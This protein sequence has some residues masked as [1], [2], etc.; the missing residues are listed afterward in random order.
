MNSRHPGQKAMVNPLII[1]PAEENGPTRF[2]VI[3][4]FPLVVMGEITAFIVAARRSR[5][6]FSTDDFNRLDNVSAILSTCMEN[7]SGIKRARLHADNLEAHN[8]ILVETLPDGLVR[9]NN[10]FEVLEANR[11]ASE[12][13]QLKPEEIIGMKCFDT[14]CN[15]K[16]ST[17]PVF[18]SERDH[19][20]FESTLP[21]H[22]GQGCN[23]VHVLKSTRRYSL[24]GEKFAICTF[25]DIS[26]LKLMDQKLKDYAENLEKKVEERTA[27]LKEAQRH[28]L[29]SEKLAATGRL[30]A[31]I[32]HEINSPVYGIK[33]CLQ[34]IRDELSLDADLRGFVDLSLEET[35]RISD[36]IRKM[37]N[38]NRVSDGKRSVQDIKSVLKDML[39]LCNPYLQEKRISLQTSFDRK[40][41]RALVC[42]D[43]I[44]QVFINL[45]NNAVEAM[46]DG[47]KLIISTRM[48]GATMEIAFEDSGCGMSTE[49]K[50]R[51][52]DAF[53]TTKSAVKGV[54]LGLPMCWGIVRRHGGNIL[55]DS[56]PGKGSTFVVI[57]PAAGKTRE[58]IPHKV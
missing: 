4:A 24:G 38:L 45:I 5:E 29:Q 22:N 37:Q 46:Q 18:S 23:E 3:A 27:D 55:V 30:A 34:S 25:K 21:V 2:P 9:V 48:R 39:V 54:G 6:S 57:L 12:L 32:A 31:S 58:K 36:L 53:F 40:M 33:G 17:C 50:K 13:L 44:K 28:L 16:R 56:K 26:K 51:V 42:E 11:Y 19:L 14:V 41:Y 8:R 7:Q 15:E 1:G 43:E 20:T 52:F 49:V 10:R 35:D 47:G